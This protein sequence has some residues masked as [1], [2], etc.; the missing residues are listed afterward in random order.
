MRPATA[1]CCLLLLAPQL[2]SGDA[3]TPRSRESPLEQ[4]LDYVT[5]L[6]GTNYGWW[7]GGAIPSG[8]P[9]WAAD[10]AA[11]PLATVR[12]SSCFCAGIPNLMLRV[13][14]RPVPCER[15][16]ADPVGGHWCGGTGAYGL[17]FSTVATPFSLERAASY[18]RGTLLGIRYHSVSNQGHVAV[19]LGAGPGGLLLQSFANSGPHGADP[20][21]PGVNTN[22]TLAECNARYE[23]CRFDYAVAPAD[24]L[25]GSSSS[26]SSSEDSN[27]GS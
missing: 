21:H 23:F 20:T 9:A 14:G 2:C 16:R 11:P 13:V 8:A 6:A 15:G 17:N 5:L 27:G 3:A 4:A 19:L 7:T 18:E 12:G 10:A 22:F 25:L 1:A 26:S 24:W